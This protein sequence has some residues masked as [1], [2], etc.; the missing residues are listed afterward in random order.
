MPNLKKIKS[1]QKFRTAVREIL[2]KLKIIK[3][4]AREDDFGESEY[5]TWTAENLSTSHGT[6]GD[7][8]IDS[9][10][11]SSSTNSVK[12]NRNSSISDYEELYE[13]VYSISRPYSPSFSTKRKRLPNTGSNFSKIPILSEIPKINNPAAWVSSKTQKDTK[14]IRN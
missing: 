1:L 7:S 8:V 3:P 12:S 2:F 4:E 6:L 5:V 9:R 13:D 11:R 10:T 14:P